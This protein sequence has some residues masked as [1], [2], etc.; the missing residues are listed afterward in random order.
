MMT[1]NDVM[2]IVKNVINNTKEVADDISE[3]A[4]TPISETVIT[5]IAVILISAV[6]VM[7]CQFVGTMLGSVF[8]A[9]NAEA[10]GCLALSAGIIIFAA[11]AHGSIGWYGVLLTIAT[12]LL[13]AAIAGVQLYFRFIGKNMR[14]KNAV[15]ELCATFIAA[16][17]IVSPQF[18][19]LLPMALNK[20]CLYLP[21]ATLI[22]AGAE[23]FIDPLVS[24]TEDDDDII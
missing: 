18:Y 9:L 23:N 4:K 21:S 2:R 8:R 24:G 22:V 13:G 3:A 15:A 7:I 1:F 16:M 14:M 11:N 17:F 19:E 6:V 10:G 5:V 20:W 12:A